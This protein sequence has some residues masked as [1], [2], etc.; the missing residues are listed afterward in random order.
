MWWKVI[1]SPPVVS[2]L[3][4]GHLR[5]DRKTTTIDKVRAIAKHIETL[6]CEIRPKSSDLKM[7][8]YMELTVETLKHLLGNAFDFGYRN[9]HEF[10][11]ELI[12]ELM[13]NIQPEEKYRVYKCEELK[14]MPEGTLF[15]HTT[16]GR[17]WI[18]I[19]PDG[20]KAMQFSK[21]GSTIGII[22]DNE[23]WDRPMKLLHAEQQEIQMI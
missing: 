2:T 12:N 4:R 10:K 23:P 11:D 1:D 17:C 16:R 15:H 8:K 21:G 13:S 9:S 22:N 20:K 3:P 5:A 6:A 19:R 7:E 14:A 18:V